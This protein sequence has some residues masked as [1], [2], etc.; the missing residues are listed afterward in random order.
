VIW[1]TGAGNADKVQQRKFEAS[2]PTR[3]ASV[4]KPFTSIAVMQLFEQELVDLDAPIQTYIPDYPVYQEGAVTIRH[5]LT[6]TSGID[7][8]RNDKERENRIEYASLSDAISIFRDRPLKFEP[9]SE[10]YYTTYG[11][12]LLGYIIERVSGMSYS[13]YLEEHIWN[14]AGMTQTGIERTYIQLPGKSQ[15]YHRQDNGKIKSAEAT[16]LSDRIPGGGIYSTIP[17]LLRFGDAIINNTL[18]REATFKLMTESPGLKSEGNGYGFGWYLYGKN[19]VYGDVIGHTGGQTG[20]S[21][22]FMLLPE[23]RT[24]IA[25]LSNTSGAM[26]EVSNIAVQLF[27]IAAEAGK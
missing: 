8:Y 16:N 7:D 13:A 14:K 23:E 3:I 11:Y 6:H 5:L 20:C 25:V 9:G 12:V 4:T 26:R 2:T 18:L 15:I 27:D 17:D 22:M 24:T 21:A 1:A 10:F 19:P